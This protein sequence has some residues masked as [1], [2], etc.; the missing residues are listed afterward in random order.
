MI[1]DTSLAADL[2]QGKFQAI[3]PVFSIIGRWSSTNEVS[4]WEW[5]NDSSNCF[6][7]WSLRRPNGMIQRVKNFEAETILLRGSLN[8][9]AATKQNS[10][11]P[12][13]T[14]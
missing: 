7:I 9:F 11:H 12:M 14:L 8:N 6:S 5:L 3:H 1:I 13:T 2:R 10:C 4:C